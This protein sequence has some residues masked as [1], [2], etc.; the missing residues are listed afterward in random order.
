MAGLE[1]LQKYGVE[2]ADVQK[3]ETLVKLRKLYVE[4][5]DGLTGQAASQDAESESLLSQLEASLESNETVKTQ[6]AEVRSAILA[7]VYDAIDANTDVVIPLVNALQEVKSAAMLERDFQ[8]SKVQRSLAPSK[9]VVND[10]FMAKRSEAEDLAEL[11]RNLWTLVK[12]PQVVE[13]F[14]KS[15]AKSFPLREQQEGKGDER[16]GTGE[17]IPSLP[18]LPRLPSDGTAVVGRNASQKWMRFAWNGDEIPAGTFVTDVA[19]DYVSDRKQG[20]VVD[21]RGLIDA[22]EK[23]GHKFTSE[24]PWEVVFPT[25][26]L[27]GWLPAKS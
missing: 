17:F 20:F 24:E 10:D 11:I 15:S 13:S 3:P 26:T 16:H 14:Q 5:V 12:S 27:R 4:L 22:V 9:P 1:L 21:H 23:S 6:V 8:K 2:L 18:N 7:L 25:G 19:H